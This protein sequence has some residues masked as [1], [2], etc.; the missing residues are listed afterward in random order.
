MRLA[1]FRAVVYG[2]AVFAAALLLTFV[3]VLPGNKPAEILFTQAASPSWK[4]RYD[5]L[6][7]GE[8]LIRVFRRGGLSDE[9]AVRAIQA[10]SGSIDPRRVRAGMPIT[11]RSGASDSTPS[12]VM[13]QLAIDKILRIKREG[14]NWQAEEE[15]IPWTTDTIVVSGTIQS[16]LYAAIDE[17]AAGLIAEKRARDQLTWA[18]A[19][20]YDFKVDMSRE[21]QKGDEF[22]VMAER[23]TLATGAVKIDRILAATFS[24]SGSTMKAVRFNSAKVGGDFF[25][26]NGRSLRE[27]FLKTPIAFRYR[28]SSVFGS[29]RHPVLGTIRNHKGTDYAAASGTPIR[30]IGDGTVIRAGWGG[31][32]GN[33]VEIRHPNG[34]VTRYGHMRGFA[35]GI[36]GG[37]RVKMGDNI[38]YV[39]TTGLSTGPHLHFEV[40]INGQQR[41]SRS[42]FRSANG[43]PIPSAERD[44]FQSIR[45]QLLPRVENVA[46]NTAVTLAGSPER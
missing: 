26:E 7:N 5:T 18:L 11:Y 31:G 21:L 39:G 43:D 34:Y 44:Q 1:Y 23:S 32:Y 3:P 25:D 2:V 20:V 40:I 30:A 45:D 41:D 24:L 37:A 35:K 12:E 38:G 28:I 15:M 13:F 10:S 6:K 17:A 9:A 29:R 46:K 8:S 19:D 36:R 33:V 4:L 42:A 14:E 16:N 27:A 22:K